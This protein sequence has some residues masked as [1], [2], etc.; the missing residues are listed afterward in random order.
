MT[1]T[2]YGR[3]GGFT[4]PGLLGQPTHEAKLYTILHCEPEAAW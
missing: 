3:C 4:E 2:L 1:E